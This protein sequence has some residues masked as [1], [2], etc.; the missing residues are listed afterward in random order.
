MLAALVLMAGSAGTSAASG[1][2]PPLASSHVYLII[3]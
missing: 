2:T 3:G 1:T